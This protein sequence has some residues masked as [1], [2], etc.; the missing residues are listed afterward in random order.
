MNFHPSTTVDNVHPVLGLHDRCGLGS[1]R[2]FDWRA[3]L[4]ELR[5]LHVCVSHLYLVELFCGV[6][7]LCVA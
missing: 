2:F 5:F 7:T 4:E 6:F 3:A 1:V